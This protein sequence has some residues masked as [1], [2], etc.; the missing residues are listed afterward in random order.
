MVNR[1]NQPGVTPIYH[2]VQKT[3]KQLEKIVQ[4]SK[5]RVLKKIYPNGK[6]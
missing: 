3:E 4:Q 5:E 1:N 2:E 6:K